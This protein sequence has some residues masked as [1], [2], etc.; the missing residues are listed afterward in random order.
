MTRRVS[1]GAEERLDRPLPVASWALYDFAN[2]IFYAVVVTRYLPQH[3]ERLTGKHSTVTWGFYPAMLAA[4]FLAPS[5]GRWVGRRGCSK[6]AVLILTLFCAGFTASLA[7]AREAWELV[8]LFALAQVLYQLALVPY[9]NLLPAVAS[10]ARMGRISG[11]GVGV[12]YLGSI[13]ALLTADALMRIWPGTG[14]AYLS[15]AVLF[16][17]FTLPLLVFVPE[18]GSE[19]PAPLAGRREVAA[20]LRD[21]GRR[22]FIFGNFLCADA[23]NAV[24]AWLVVYLDRGFGFGSSQILFV[25]VAINVAAAAGGVGV[26]WSA[27]R[28]G[29]KAT[30]ILSAAA[31]GA[32]VA[33]AQYSG[34]DAIVTWSIVLLGG[35]GVAGLWVAGRKWVVELSPEGRTGAFFGV[36]GMTNK[37]SVINVT[38]FA[39]LADW[40]GGYSASV[41]ALLLSIL[42][43][44]AFLARA[45]R[46][47]RGAAGEPG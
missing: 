28:I 22:R 45:G 38:L 21:P 41:L 18:K 39:W 8:L 44:I 34:S 31:L 27:D 43:G 30:M 20:L 25:L 26:G 35:P 3:V 7:L 12:G 14:T 37:L 15:A 46:G 4:A 19:P 36:Y 29:S 2:T 33:L 6:R 24:I 13:A 42:A 10:R 32:A 40:T 16:A 17:L 9:N 23:L 47:R 1:G 5:L 11:Y